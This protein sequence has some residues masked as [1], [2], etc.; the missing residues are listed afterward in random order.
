M[1]P[2]CVQTKL[3]VRAPRS[4]SLA[5]AG[6]GHGF[7]PHS[8]C[9]SRARFLF[10]SATV[11]G[12]GCCGRR[13]AVRPQG[14]RQRRHA[15]SVSRSSPPGWTGSPSGSAGGGSR[16]PGRAEQ[17]DQKMMAERVRRRHEPVPSA[18]SRSATSKSWNVPV[19]RMSLKPDP[20]SDS[21]NAVTS[22][23]TSLSLPGVIGS[24]L[25][26]LPSGSTTRPSS[27][28]VSCRRQKRYLTDVGTGCLL[29]TARRIVQ[30][31]RLRQTDLSH[32]PVSE[33][34]SR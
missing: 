10:I 33:S 3:P 7:S 24:G 11:R 17:V 15:G 12:S 19:S 20:T 9:S 23:R 1:A 32:P 13:G 29:S 28:D 25:R 34:I 27:A 8:C 31:A 21:D 16:S 22:P 6:C 26:P 14:R 5:N 18:F 4:Y 30:P 2:H